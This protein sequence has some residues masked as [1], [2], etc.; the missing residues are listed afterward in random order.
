MLVRIGDQ[1][2]DTCKGR[3]PIAHISL[4]GVRADK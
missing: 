4:F 1:R 3:W 2:A